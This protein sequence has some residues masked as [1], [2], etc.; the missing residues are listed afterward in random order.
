MIVS[1]KAVKVIKEEEHKKLIERF[2]NI[3]ED[4]HQDL[5]RLG[6]EKG[7]TTTSSKK[8]IEYDVTVGASSVQS[9]GGTVCRSSVTSTERAGDD[10]ES[11]EN[12]QRG[13]DD[14]S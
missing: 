2:V 7:I 3:V 1:I 12:E 10:A 8:A 13:K 5:P 4:A 11:D 14:S 6:L 9:V